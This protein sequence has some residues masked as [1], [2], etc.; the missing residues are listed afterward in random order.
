[1]ADDSD[2][3]L[4]PA[5]RE[6]VKR[7]LAQGYQ[8]GDEIKHEWFYEAFGLD[9]PQPETPLRQAERTKLQFLS[10]FEEL[11]AELLEKHQ[12]ALAN[13]RGYGYRVVPAVQ[14]TRWAEAECVEQV[15]S[16]MRKMGERLSNVNMARLD[17]DQR[18]ENADA[19]A[20]LSMMA[21]ML[22]RAKQIT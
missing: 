16:A 13:V 18:K 15:K 14:Q 7:F 4:Y 12:I 22:K 17:A 11:R 21:S 10:A 8:E 3:L 2:V 19:L 6:G 1:M 9:M 20:R 5:W